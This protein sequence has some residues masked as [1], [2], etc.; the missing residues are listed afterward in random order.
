MT[1]TYWANISLL[2]LS[3]GISTNYTYISIALSLG[4]SIILLGVGI[5]FTKMRV[6]DNNA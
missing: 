5:I 6:G 1:P 3:S 4:L 2:S